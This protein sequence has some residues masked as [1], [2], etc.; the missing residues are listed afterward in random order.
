MFIT[1]HLFYHILA[2]H[3]EPPSTQGCTTEDLH[4]QVSGHSPK[5]QLNGEHITPYYDHR[6]VY[7]TASTQIKMVNMPQMQVLTDHC[8]QLP[9]CL[10][11]LPCDSLL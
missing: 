3:T 5:T 2:L 6:H 10:E 9:L 1:F 8:H 4:H 11:K 7:T